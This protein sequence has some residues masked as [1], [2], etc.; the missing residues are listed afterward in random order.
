M[1][2]TLE[3]E[4]V[5]RELRLNAGAMPAVPA[6]AEPVF[7]SALAPWHPALPAAA[8]ADFASGLELINTGEPA[9]AARHL[10][11]VL[12]VA[13]DFADG[14]VA[15]GM[16][17]AMVP[18]VYPALDHLEKATKL[19]PS[20]FF[21]HFKRGQLYFKLRIPREGYNEMTHAL[22]CATSVRERKLVSELI[23]EEKQREH[24]GVRRPWWNKPF[25]RT[26]LYVAASL[27]AMA[28]VALLRFMHLH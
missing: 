13:P 23:R 12:E 16:A 21:A 24:S 20:N 2:R 18:R 8:Q 6:A 5:G 1:S 28:G 22:K 25:S 3:S 26:A 9:L 7:D 4:T 11:R 15:L 10:K 27:A 19:D 17:Y 14:H